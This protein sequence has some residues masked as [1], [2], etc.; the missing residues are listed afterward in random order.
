LSPGRRTNR[1]NLRSCQRTILLYSFYKSSQRKITLCNHLYFQS[2]AARPQAGDRKLCNRAKH[3][4]LEPAP[5]AAFRDRN[6]KKKDSPCGCYL[7][8]L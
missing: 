3:F 4:P 8:P 2:S 5:D 7:T 1:K 6:S